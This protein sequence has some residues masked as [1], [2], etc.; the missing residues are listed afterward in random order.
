VVPA[1]AGLLHLLPQQL[2]AQVVAARVL[3]LQRV[4][5]QVQQALRG[6]DSL[7]GKDI[8]A[9]SMLTSKLAV[10]AVVPAQLVLMGSPVVVMAV[11]VPRLLSREHL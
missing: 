6:K 5:V 10:A 7:V 3:S 9:M 1:Q 11:P 2:A 8:A 4:L